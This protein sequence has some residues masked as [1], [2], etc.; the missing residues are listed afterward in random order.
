[1]VKQHHVADIVPGFSI[2]VVTEHESGTGVIG[3]YDALD[4]PVGRVLEP[5]PLEPVALPSGG[6]KVLQKGRSRHN[7]DLRIRQ[8]NEGS[9]EEK[10]RSIGHD[11]HETQRPLRRPDL[12]AE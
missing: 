4:K 3:R 2:P 11:L 7:V 1:M 6:E 5:E 10:T 12:W 8:G 9:P